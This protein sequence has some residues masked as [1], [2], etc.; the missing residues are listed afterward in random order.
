[1]RKPNPIADKVTKHVLEYLL[2]QFHLQPG[3]INNIRIIINKTLNNN[4]KEQKKLPEPKT[5]RTKAP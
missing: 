5:K 1:M 4:T 3:D 2:T